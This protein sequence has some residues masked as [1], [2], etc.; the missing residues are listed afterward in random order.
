[1]RVHQNIHGGPA[2]FLPTMASTKSDADQALLCL[3]HGRKP[4]SITGGD[5]RIIDI[6]EMF[7]GDREVNKTP[8]FTEIRHI[9]AQQTSTLERIVN[10]PLRTR[11]EFHETLFFKLRRPQ[12]VGPQG[13]NRFMFRLCLLCFL[14]FLQPTKKKR[15]NK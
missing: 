14:G 9:Q 11:K 3:D 5:I 6:K 2:C 15:R 1:M 10:P 7:S 8:I 13:G 12:H 4:H